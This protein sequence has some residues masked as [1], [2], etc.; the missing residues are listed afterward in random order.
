MRTEAVR[1]EVQRM[2]RHVPF[3]AFTIAMED[4]TRIRIEHPENIAFDPV[5]NGSGGSLDFTIHS[6]TVRYYGTFDAVT[7]VVTSKS[8]EENEG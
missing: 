4:G 5:N 6:E 1:T 3:R 8:E 7:G 2:V